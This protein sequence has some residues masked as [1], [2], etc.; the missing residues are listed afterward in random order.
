MVLTNDVW[1]AFKAQVDL[2]LNAWKCSS[3]SELRFDPQDNADK[4]V[5]TSFTD[6]NGVL[7]KEGDPDWE[8]G[9][10]SYAYGRPAVPE[11]DV[12]DPTG[13]V[14]MA[15][16]EYAML[17]ALMARL[18]KDQPGMQTEHDQYLAAAKECLFKVINESSKGDAPGMP[19][20]QPNFAVN[21]RSFANEA[22]PLTVDWIYED[23]TPLELAKVRKTFLLWAEQCNSHFYFSPYR[24]NGQHGTPNSP[25]LFHF[26]DPEEAERHFQVR[27]GLNNHWGNH[28]R[29]MVLYGLALDP[30]DDV[31]VELGDPAYGIVDDTAPAGAVTSQIVGPGGPQDWVP[32]D[33]GV[34]RDATGVWLYITDY[35]YRHDGAGGPS[36]EGT[37]YSSNGLGPVALAMAA[38]QSAGQ[39]DPN[40]WGPQVSLAN[41]PFWSRQIPSYL[42]LLAPTP[43]TTS[44]PAYSYYGDVFQPPLYGDLETYAYLNDQFIKIL[45]PLALADARTNGTTGEIAQAVRY[46]QRNLAPGGPS[47][48]AYRIGN[49]ISNRLF[50]DTI[51][52]FLLFDPVDA[53]DPAAPPLAADPRPAL[54]P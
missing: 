40:V 48:L 39:D 26:D 21:D 8:S 53:A 5:R 18:T 49:T 15:S 51:Y 9:G 43:R 22:F 6:E 36:V 11:D 16:E 10:W 47:K 54:Q 30:A 44:N 17:F 52:Y 42:S 45:A 28:L 7:H 46:I 12:G 3:T 29:E 32:I 25:E 31:P 41:H 2:C 13:H 50:R 27:L 37:Q 33:N 35:A 24:V 4:W 1:V 34:F 14:R 38:L 19:W 23:L 20:R